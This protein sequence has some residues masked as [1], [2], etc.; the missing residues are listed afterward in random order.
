[1]ASP[2]LRCTVNAE[3]TPDFEDLGKNVKNFILIIVAIR[4]DNMLIN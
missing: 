2:S 3:Y 4:Y 1:M